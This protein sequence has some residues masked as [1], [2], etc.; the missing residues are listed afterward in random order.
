VAI[1]WWL[2]LERKDYG[3]NDESKCG[4]QACQFQVARPWRQE[5]VD[6]NQRP[7][8]VLP[9][10]MGLHRCLPCGFSRGHNWMLKSGQ[11]MYKNVMEENIT[12]ILGRSRYPSFRHQRKAESRHVGCGFHNAAFNVYPTHV[13]PLIVSLQRIIKGITSTRVKGFCLGFS[14][15][16]C[17]HHFATKRPYR[18]MSTADSMA[19]HSKSIQCIQP[20]HLLPPTNHQSHDKY[21]DDKILARIFSKSLFPSFRHQ[22]PY[23]VILP[24]DSTTLQGEANISHSSQSSCASIA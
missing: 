7:V 10:K 6:G 19:L 23:W 4:Q 9:S 24:A 14:Q 1:Q 11:S 17:I 13:S 22:K 18:V 16:V 20:S 12:W 15:S 3:E 8:I 5:F 21:M 2:D